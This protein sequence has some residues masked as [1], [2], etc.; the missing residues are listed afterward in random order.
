MGAARTGSGKTLA[1]LIPVVELLYNL[2]FMPRNGKKFLCLSHK[3]TLNKMIVDSDQTVH[4]L[5]LIRAFPNILKYFH[6]PKSSVI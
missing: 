2:K 5:I 1:F 3:I 6:F 4:T